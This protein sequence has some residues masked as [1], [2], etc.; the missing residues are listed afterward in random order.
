MSQE[1]HEEHDERHSIPPTR[2]RQGVTGHHVI[3]V[4]AVSLLLAALVGSLL[5]GWFATTTPGAG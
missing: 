5:Y 3:V 2:A 1:Q 4:L